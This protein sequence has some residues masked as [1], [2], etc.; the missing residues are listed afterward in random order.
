MNLIIDAGNT[1]VKIYPTQDDKVGTPAVFSSSDDRFIQAHIKSKDFLHCIVSNVGSKS[2]L[3]YDVL[4]VAKGAFIELNGHTP[5]PVKSQY[6]TPETLGY[7]RIAN[8]V[9]ADFLFPGQNIL[10]IDAGTAL[11]YDL[12]SNSV[13]LGGAIAPGMQ[14]RF[15]AL[16]QHTSRLPSLKYM[17]DYEVPGKTT[18]DSI[19]NGVVEGIVNE[20]K[21][22][23]NTYKKEYSDLITVI[24]G[25]DADIFAKMI[26]NGI[27]A[28]PYLL[29]KGLN[30]ILNYNVEK[31]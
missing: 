30:R 21:G 6:R 3:W 11:T 15:D 26:K 19:L 10:A 28:E 12:V 20:I 23:I 4:S 5:I 7:D 9:G 18:K 24:T 17:P 27:F 2:P 25:G 16:H 8:V 22:T 31:T 29:A 14:L 13:Y 1:R